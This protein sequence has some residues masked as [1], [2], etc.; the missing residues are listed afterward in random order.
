MCRILLMTCIG[1]TLGMGFLLFALGH[2]MD[3]GVMYLVDVYFIGGS[4]GG[5]CAAMLYPALDRR[6]C[7]EF[8]K[9]DKIKRADIGEKLDK[10]PVRSESKRV[11]LPTSTS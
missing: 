11:I 8:I 3:F 2:A 5:I 4:M 7:F 1:S 10:M 6:T 9:E